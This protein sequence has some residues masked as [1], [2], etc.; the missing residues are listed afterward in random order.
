MVVF[1]FVYLAKMHRQAAPENTSVYELKYVADELIQLL[2]II[3]SGYYNDL[4]I[5]MKS[6]SIP[7]PFTLLV[8]PLFIPQE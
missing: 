7:F 8:K 5:L 6:A 1:V 3:E 4:S 2:Q